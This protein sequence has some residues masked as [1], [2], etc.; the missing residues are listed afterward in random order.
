MDIDEDRK[1]YLVL[2]ILAGILFICI[3]IAIVIFI[4]SRPIGGTE[5][6]Q[7]TAEKSLGSYTNVSF[8]LEEQVKIYSS[9]ISSLLTSNDIDGLYKILNEDY[10]KYSDFDKNKFKEYIGQKNVSGKNLNLKEYKNGKIGNNKVIKLILETDEQSN[11]VSIPVTVFE[12][13]PN[14]YTIAFDNFIAY[15]SDEVSFEENGLR[16]TL[17]NQTLFSNEYKTNIKITNISNSV[18]TLNKQKASEVFYI[19]QG[20][21]SDKKVSTNVLMGQALSLNSG[22]SINYTISFLISEFTFDSIKKF[23]IKDVTNEDTN[24]TQN[25]EINLYNS[26]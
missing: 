19:N 2:V 20:L 3:F 18:I 14:I 8:S 22:E 4:W 10:I 6:K 12:T 11:K 1:K 13:S 21:E 25:I 7:S 16:V 26:K 15:N 17:Y 5:D 23:I 24:N 9:N